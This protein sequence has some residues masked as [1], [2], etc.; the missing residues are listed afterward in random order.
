M[1]VGKVPLPLPSRLFL[2]LYFVS[3]VLFYL[4]GGCFFTFLIGSIKA[5]VFD[6][7]KVI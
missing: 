1:Y 7:R 6:I 2:L 5:T 4:E 3:F